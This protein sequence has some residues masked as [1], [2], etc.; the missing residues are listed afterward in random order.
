MLVSSRG[1]GRYGAGENRGRHMTHDTPTLL[2]AP[3]RTPS[4]ETDSGG[5]EVALDVD[6]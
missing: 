1:P 5:L 2:D 3:T 6:W 4:S